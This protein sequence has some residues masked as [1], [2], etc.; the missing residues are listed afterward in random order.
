MLVGRPLGAFHHVSDSRVRHAAQWLWPFF[1]TSVTVELLSSSSVWSC[2]ELSNFSSIPFARAA[3]ILT[4]SSFS[5]E[6]CGVISVDP[7]ADKLHNLVHTSSSG[8]RSGRP[9]ASCGSRLPRGQLVA[10]HHAFGWH[11][12]TRPTRWGSTPYPCSASRA[13]GTGEGQWT[14]S[15]WD[16]LADLPEAHGRAHADC[17]EVALVDPR[18]C[19]AESNLGEPIDAAAQGLISGECGLL[20]LDCWRVRIRVTLALY[21]GERT[22]MTRL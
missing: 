16:G 10:R 22:Y 11:P 8:R 3:R 17:G 14:D 18:I 15:F 19:E 4:F 6:L 20:F 9:R 2:R 5:F 21:V 13:S 12:R 7:E 1:L